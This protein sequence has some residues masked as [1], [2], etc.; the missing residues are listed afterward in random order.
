MPGPACCTKSQWKDLFRL[1]IELFYNRTACSSRIASTNPPNCSWNPYL[2][3]HHLCTTTD[4]VTSHTSTYSS[5]PSFSNITDQSTSFIVTTCPKH[6]NTSSSL[7]Q[8]FS[9]ISTPPSHSP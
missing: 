5:N 4:S 1:V 6:S 3:L 2:C 7:P 8:C 9:L